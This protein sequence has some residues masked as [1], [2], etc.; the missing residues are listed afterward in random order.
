MPPR[1]LGGALGN[2]GDRVLLGLGSWLAA[3][4]LN[5]SRLERR[6]AALLAGNGVIGI[7]GAAISVAR[8]EW[9]LG[10]P[11]LLSYA[12]WNAY[13]LLTLALVGLALKRRVA[14]PTP[15]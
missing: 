9:V 15:A 6:A 4:V 3:P 11:G 5:A 2:R 7:A 13:F 8:L 14:A 1:H 12:A 10:T